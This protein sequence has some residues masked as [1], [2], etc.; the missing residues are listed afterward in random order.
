MANKPEKGNFYDFTCGNDFKRVR[1]AIKGNNYHAVKIQAEIAQSVD[2]TGGIARIDEILLY[3][4]FKL[5]RVM[6]P[7][8]AGFVNILKIYEAENLAR[9]DLS[10]LHELQQLSILDCN[11]LDVL[12]GLGKNLKSI[13]I[14]GCHLKNLTLS[15]FN[16]L[17]NIILVTSSPRFD[18]KIE[19]CDALKSVTVASLTSKDPEHDSVSCNISDCKNLQTLNVVSNAAPASVRLDKCPDIREAFFTCGQES[20]ITG[21]ANCIRMNYLI[22]PEYEKILTDISRA[23]LLQNIEISRKANKIA[24]PVEKVVAN[25]N[26][27]VA[28]CK[29]SIKMLYESHQDVETIIQ[30][31]NTYRDGKRS[32]AVMIALLSLPYR[33]LEYQPSKSYHTGFMHEQKD[34]SVKTT[35]KGVMASAAGLMSKGNMHSAVWYHASDKKISPASFKIEKDSSKKD[36]TEKEKLQNKFSDIHHHVLEIEEWLINHGQELEM[37]HEELIQITEQFENAIE[38]LEHPLP[39]FLHEELDHLPDELTELPEEL[40][41]LPQDEQ[42]SGVAGGESLSEHSLLDPEES[43]EFSKPVDENKENKMDEPE[44]VR[45]ESTSAPLAENPSLIADQPEGETGKLKENADGKLKEGK[46]PGVLDIKEP[47]PGELNV[48]KP[49][50]SAEKPSPVD[51]VLKTQPSLIAD[52]AQEQH[53]EGIGVQE[54]TNEE[55]LTPGNLDVTK[56]LKPATKVTSVD[57]ALSSHPSLLADEVQDLHLGRITIEEN[58]NDT[59]DLMSGELSINKQPLKS[60]GKT[61]ITG[62]G[63]LQKASLIAGESEKQNLARINVQDFMLAAKEFSGV[64]SVLTDAAR[65]E[66]NPAQSDQLL[67][68]ELKTRAIFKQPPARNPEVK[69]EL[70]AVAKNLSDALRE[71]HGVCFAAYLK[72]DTPKPE[73][74]E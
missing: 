51:E 42:A 52:E 16:K 61:S 53:L 3:K 66:V 29:S 17:E 45:S 10:N 20:E 4:C 1:L 9:L 26:K 32:S 60:A 43:G 33:S 21:L 8:Q 54:T 59:S 55:K 38:E 28:A 24:E 58:I 65:A 48:K 2:F 12:S 72:D 63:L 37:K 13:L 73:K 36:K 50:K 70:L 23:S 7:E 67:E 39:D 5:T 11:E 18:L 15:Q 40:A 19:H 69:D 31:N 30:E 6:W 46:L 41:E 44:S 49:L 71:L 74:S 68:M 64:L 25:Y 14:F 35:P 27:Y 47:L 56:H 57:E 62:K 22:L 34:K